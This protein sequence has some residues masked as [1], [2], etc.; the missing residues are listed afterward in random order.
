MSPKGGKRTGAGRKPTGKPTGARMHIY[1]SGDNID[2][3]G[4][5]A[6]GKRSEWINKAIRNE[7]KNEMSENL[8]ALRWKVAAERF[9]HEL[10]HLRAVL[11]SNGFWECPVCGTWN[12]ETNICD[13]CGLDPDDI[14]ATEAE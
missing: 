8:E 14:D 9:A 11:K 6:E 1:L 5:L 13:T 4:R 10:D 2:Y 7:R 3:I 12:P